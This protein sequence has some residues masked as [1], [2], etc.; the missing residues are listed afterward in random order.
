MTRLAATPGSAGEIY[1]LSDFP[2]EL[3]SQISAIAWFAPLAKERGVRV[4]PVNMIGPV[5]DASQQNVSI[6]SITLGTDLLVAGVPTRLYIDA[7]NHS[8]RQAVAVFDIS[9]SHIPLKRQ[10]VRLNPDEHKRIAIAV[11][12]P[13]APGR[14]FRWPSNPP[15]SRRK[16]RAISWSM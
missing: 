9:A 3:E 13:P 10:N 2:R 15:D 6:D 14:F 12:L 7:S 8:D 5:D 4:A 16:A 11:S 1:L